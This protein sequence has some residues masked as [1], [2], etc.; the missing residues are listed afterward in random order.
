MHLQYINQ[1][2]KASLRYVGYNDSTSAIFHAGKS[3]GVVNSICQLLER[4]LS[5]GAD[6]NKH[7]FPSIEMILMLYYLHWKKIR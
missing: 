5:T 6:T 7:L 3:I 2:P 4:Q 1:R